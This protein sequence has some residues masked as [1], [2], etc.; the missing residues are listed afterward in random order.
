MSKR[1]QLVLNENRLM[2]PDEVQNDGFFKAVVDT[3]KNDEDD[4]GDDTEMETGKDNVEKEYGQR[5]TIG[6]EC[7]TV[8]GWE[9]ETHTEDKN[10]AT[11]NEPKG[12]E[13]DLNK[14]SITREI[15]DKLIVIVVEKVRE[16]DIPIPSMSQDNKYFYDIY[17]DLTGTLF[18]KGIYIPVGQTRLVPTN[19]KF[20]VP[21]GYELQVR[22]KMEYLDEGVIIQYTPISIIGKQENELKIVVSNLGNNATTVQHGQKIAQFILAPLIGHTSLVENEKK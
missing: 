15:I 3:L 18:G 4:T 21:E 19:L 6:D 2:N 11:E 12:K 10:S 16:S 13:L 22:S 9:K 7:K 5:G 14:D 20:T 1:R 8:T 17:V